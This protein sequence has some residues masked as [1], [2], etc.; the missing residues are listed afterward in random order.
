MIA[1]AEELSKPSKSKESVP[2][3]NK[4][5][6]NTEPI[7]ELSEVGRTYLSSEPMHLPAY[8]DEFKHGGTKIEDGPLNQH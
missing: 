5:L 2:K 6:L 3:Y 1:Y 7:N 4:Q 8:L